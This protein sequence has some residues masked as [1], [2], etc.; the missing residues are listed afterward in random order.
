MSVKR[1]RIAV[2]H[3]SFQWIGGAEAVAVWTLEALKEKYDITLIAANDLPIDKVNDFFGTQLAPGDFQIAR[4]PFPVGLANT[5]KFWHLKR[6]LAMRYCRAVTTE[7]DLFIS[8]YNEMD[9]GRTGIQYVV[10]PSFAAG[11]INGLEKYLEPQHRSR[12]K[13]IYRKIS[14]IVLGCSLQ[15]IKQNVTLVDSDWTGK[16]LREAYDIET[17]TVYPPVPADF[18]DV[19]WNERE[20]GFVCIGRLAPNK[21]IDMIIRILRKVRQL[22]WDVHLHII[23][24]GGWNSDYYRLIKQLQEENSDWIFLEIGLTR[25]QLAELVSQH[26]YGIHGMRNEHFG[27][28]VAEMAKAGNIVFV[29]NDGGQ[30]EIINDERL[31][32]RSEEEATEKIVRVLSNSQDQVDIRNHLKSRVQLFSV[33]RF[34]EQIRDIVQACLEDQGCIDQP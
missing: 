18:R 6:L 21:R 24:G 31:I 20:E 32:Y 19:P 23:T 30:V 27:I 22:G 4:I 16:I 9:F 15:R 33:E 1:A 12:Y 13:K 28:A 10:S 7:Y 17:R 8:T 26:K 11:M 5:P 2:V 3:I 29:P 25:K 34:M 14:A